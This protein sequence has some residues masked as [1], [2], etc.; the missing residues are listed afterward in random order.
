MG[1][2]IVSLDGYFCSPEHNFD[3]KHAGVS[4][5]NSAVLQIPTVL[6]RSSSERISCADN[7]RCLTRFAAQVLA[8]K[9]KRP[10]AVNSV[11]ERLVHTDFRG[12]FAVLRLCDGARNVIETHEYKENFKD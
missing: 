2:I 8:S 4:R 6:R 12:L 11:V 10:R 3:S 9:L 7:D 1:E 5:V